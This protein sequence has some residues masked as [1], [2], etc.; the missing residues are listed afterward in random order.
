MSANDRQASTTRVSR[1][2]AATPAELYAAFMDPAV[3]VQWLPPGGMT[4]QLHAFDGRVGGGYT[5]SLFYPS[6]D[7]RFS[8]KTAAGEDR[9]SVRFLQLSPG[10]RIVE[11]V[12]FDTTDPAL[13]GDMTITV[14][15][16]PVTGARAAPPATEVT[17]VCENL[18]PGL[19]AEDNAEGSRLS[20]EQ[21]ARRF[22]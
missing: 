6:D 2:I 1:L 16:A 3:L 22:E 7:T 20:L 4:G 17:F 18:P 14:T 21:L 15:F 19:K 9:A 8:G 13:M 12:T 5:M 11:A 10:R